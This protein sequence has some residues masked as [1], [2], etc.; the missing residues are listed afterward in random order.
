M[1]GYDPRLAARVWGRVYPSKPRLKGAQRQNLTACLLR[2][3]R[4]LP[5][6]E[7]LS[8]H[9]VYAHAFRHLA[10]QTREEIRMLKEILTPQRR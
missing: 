8:E 4:N 5:V 7:G 1:E 6:Y 3:Q 9:P 2:A 10:Q